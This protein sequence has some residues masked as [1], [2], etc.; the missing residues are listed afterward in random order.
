MWI[1]IIYPGGKKKGE[2]TGTSQ[3]SYCYIG[4]GRKTRSCPL[5]AADHTG[6][7]SLLESLEVVSEAAIALRTGQPMLTCNQQLWV[8]IMV[9]AKW[10]RLKIAVGYNLLSYL[11]QLLN[12]VLWCLLKLLPSLQ[13]LSQCLQGYFHTFG[14]TPLE[15]FGSTEI[16]WLLLQSKKGWLLVRWNTL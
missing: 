13:G 8:M 14:L 1:I 4:S 16:S 7:L 2:V 6:I 10:Q 11:W 5:G 12:P 3:W 9:L 15:K